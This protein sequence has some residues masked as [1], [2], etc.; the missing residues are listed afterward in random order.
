MLVFCLFA[1][2][3]VSMCV[4][5]TL[6]HQAYGQHAGPKG[7][8]MQARVILVIQP[9]VKQ[10]FVTQEPQ[11][12]A[13]SE[14]DEAPVTQPHALVLVQSNTHVVQDE[15]KQALRPRVTASRQGPL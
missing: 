8:G 11:T 10:M 9:V 14:S 2:C 6:Q 3:I 13:L 7:K 15:S 12:V 4:L 5:K 1:I